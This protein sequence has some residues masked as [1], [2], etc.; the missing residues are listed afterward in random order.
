MCGWQLACQLLPDRNPF[1]GIKKT[2][3]TLLWI[4]NRILY[5]FFPFFWYHT[6]DRVA[7][8]KEH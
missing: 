5:I 6:C 1:K 4:K 8:N 7:L 3:K 2:E